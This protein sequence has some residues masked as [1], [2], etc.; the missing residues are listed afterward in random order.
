VI[1]AAKNEREVT[2][3]TFGRKTGKPYDV[4]I[5]VVTDGHRL[6][7][8]SGQGMARQWP[9]NLAARGMGSCSSEVSTSMSSR[10]T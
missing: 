5:F 8:V 6:F 2:F 9:R 3:T 10:G 7:I 1:D 4:T